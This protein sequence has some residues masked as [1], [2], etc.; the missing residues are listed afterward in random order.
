MED[1]VITIE[2]LNKVLE[3]EGVRQE[4]VYIARLNKAAVGSMPDWVKALRD[5]IVGVKSL[6]DKG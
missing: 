1:K 6:E 5:M 4:L 3:I 2:V